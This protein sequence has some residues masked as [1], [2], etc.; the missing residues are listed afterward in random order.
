MKAGLI[1]RTFVWLGRIRRC[2]GFGVQSPWAYSLVCDVINA[3][4]TR[5]DYERLSLRFGH[6]S[7]IERKL[8]KL[9]LRLAER[10][11]P[12]IAANVSNDD[13]AFRAYINAGCPTTE[14]VTIA[15][16]H[17]D[18]EERRCAF[19]RL[20]PSESLFRQIGE[21]SKAAQDGWTV[22][23]EDIH[24][25]ANTRQAWSKIVKELPQTVTFDL[26]YCGLIFFDSKRY[27]QNYIINF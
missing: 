9:Y 1:W 20:V 12:D 7:H 16:L 15:S 23:V 27:K 24:G 10:I 13:E 25:C 22:I 17:K 6:L 8:Y 26:Y 11:K 4:D 2:K 14:F 5:A 19:I 3:H 21:I 18:G